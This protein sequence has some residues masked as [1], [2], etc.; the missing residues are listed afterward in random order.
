MK[1]EKVYTYLLAT[2]MLAIMLMVAGI[3]AVVIMNGVPYFWLKRV[4][5]FEMQDG[6]VHT[7]EI[8]ER[9]RSHDGVDEIKIKTGNR[10]ALG[11]DFLFIKKNE[12]KSVTYPDA[13]VLIERMEWGNAYGIPKDISVEEMYTR[14]KISSKARAAIQKFE[15]KSLVE[16][17]TEI[18]KINHEIEK[19]GRA[20]LAPGLAKLREQAAANEEKLAV[21]RAEAGTSSM[22]ITLADGSE[23]EI[24]FLDIVNIYRP[25]HAGFFSKAGTAIFK[26]FEFIF[27]D[28]RESNTEG[29][30]A[31]AIFGTVLLVMLMSIAV[32]PLGVVTAV[33]LNEYAREGALLGLIR[34]TIYN[35]AG[36]PSIVYGVFGLAFFVYIVGSSIDHIFYA[37]FLPSPTFGTG[38]ILWASLTLAV[39]TLPVVIVASL[40]GL[41]AVPYMYREGA[42]SL[43][44]TKWEVIRDVVI[45]NAMPGMLT[46]L[47]LA[48]SRAAGEVAPLMLTGVVKSAVN[49]PLDTTLPFIHL[50]RKFMHLGFHIYDVGFQSP[51][52]EAA[53]PMVFLTTLV[54]LAIV[55]A[56][57]LVAIIIRNRLRKKFTRS[58]V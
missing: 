13:M 36:V 17:N 32:F 24:A 25:N 58:G 54:L 3:F 30:I 12:I 34:N 18:A 4:A 14:L 28:P 23:E 2:G 29:G 22:T 6:T 44:A 16:L 57:N 10:R 9:V 52:I 33:F 39:L 37:D 47:I 5:R 49:L 41:K 15:K 7:G 27:A 45:P 55:F 8:H 38:G 26:F 50:E 53:R 51:N 1:S 43:G 42:Y 48:I 56:L 11:Q 40:E 46:G 21:M 19:K 35:L 31:P 20:E